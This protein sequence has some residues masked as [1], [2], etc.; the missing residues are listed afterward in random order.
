MVLI[1][2]LCPVETSIRNFH[3]ADNMSPHGLVIRTRLL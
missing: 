3:R 2:G 1:I